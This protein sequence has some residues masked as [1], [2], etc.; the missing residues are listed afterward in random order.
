MKGDSKLCDLGSCFL[1]K[2]CQQEW[3]PAV[4]AHRKN[5][6]IRKGQQLFTEGDAV[7]GI[8]FIY[9]GKVKVHKRWDKEKEL[10]IRFAKGGDIVGHLG[11]GDSRQYPISATALEPVTVCYFD[12]S[13]FQATLTVNN[14]LTIELLRFFANELQ[15]SE[16]RM[17]NLVHMPVKARIAQSLIALRQQFDLNAE[18][19]I[20]IELSRQDLASYSGASYETLFKVLTEWSG[21]KSILLSGKRIKVKNE[22]ALLKL[23]EV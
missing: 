5:I 19:F 3:L 11:L 2:L 22:R 15:E 6:E 18:G 20:D 16:K 12:M 21:Q 8:Y 14:G 7:Q 10:I 13:F 23:I 17:R 9:K 4:A 1:C